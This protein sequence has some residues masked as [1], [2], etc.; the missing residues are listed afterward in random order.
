M[1]KKISELTAV[2]SLTGTEEFEVNQ[3]GTSKKA[4]ASQIVTLASGGGVTAQKYTSGRWYSLFQTHTSVI[5]TAATV[6]TI[7]MVP[8][9]IH[10]SVTISDLMARVTTAAAGGN[11]QYAV[12]ASDTA[13][14]PTGTALTSTGNLS[15]ASIG[16]VSATLGA[17]LT[18]SPGLYWAAANQDNATG[19]CL[20]PGPNTLLGLYGSTSPS[21]IAS[22][23][24]PNNLIVASTFGTWPDLTATT[25]TESTTIHGPMMY[26]KVA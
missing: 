26:Y 11:I 10:K 6:N 3:S 2:S 12:Y 17:N 5:G 24:P 14:K 15:M 25:P 22:A 9:L 8:F 7:R 20:A 19:V 4:T 23:G 21:T 13:G 18:L 1:V 16:A